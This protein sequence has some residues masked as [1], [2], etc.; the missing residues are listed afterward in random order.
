MCTKEQKEKCSLTHNYI[1][2]LQKVNRKG[3]VKKK[4]NTGKCEIN[5]STTDRNMAKLNNTKIDVVLCVILKVLCVVS[6]PFICISAASKPHC[7][8]FTTPWNNF[9]T[10]SSTQENQTPSTPQVLNSNSAHQYWGY[11]F[12]TY[13][14]F[15]WL[16]P[17]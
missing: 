12:L 13:H 9:Y 14:W 4:K 5:G 2:L 11:S 7:S 1:E 17:E 10:S 6:G 16:T 3:E 15:Y 8:H